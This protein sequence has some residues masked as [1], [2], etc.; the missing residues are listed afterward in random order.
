MLKNLIQRIG[1]GII[2]GTPFLS[3]FVNKGNKT[4]ENKIDFV[5]MGTEILFVFVLLYLMKQF[6]TNVSDLKSIFELL[7]F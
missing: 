7:K 6:G 5:V 1:K 3:T 2:N 4:E